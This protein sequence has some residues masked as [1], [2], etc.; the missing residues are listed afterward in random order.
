MQ[1]AEGTPGTGA[2]A[3]GARRARRRSR[4][5]GLAV[6]AGVALLLACLPAVAQEEQSNETSSEFVEPIVTEETLPNEVGEWD[7]RLSCG[8]TH[9]EGARRADCVR[10]QVFFGI[11]RGLG[12]EVS[13]PLTHAL[14]TPG[15]HGLGDFSA[16]V[17]YA[18]R[19]PTRR[20]PA[21]VLGLESTF[22]TGETS[23]GTGE[24]VYELRPNVA[25]LQKI[26]WA[27]L[28]GNV[29]YAVAVG[30]SGGE[31]GNQ[32]TFNGSAAF[33]LRS[34]QW[35]LLAEATG[36]FASNFR[37]VLVAPGIKYT[38]GRN[39]FLALG[40]PVGVTAD[41]PAF[42]VIVQMQLS[43]RERREDDQGTST[44]D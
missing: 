12:G 23:N 21:I 40:V 3:P 13:L 20:A 43:L 44:I 22:P 37:Q 35:Y 14:D 34:R 39:R 4:R 38:F 19:A 18:L 1:T 2:T 36:T 25:F 5:L 9:R 6:A 41:S 8:Y 31:E 32:G 7:L 17:K 30:K 24:G 28:Q 27:T 29:G 16:A 11:A 33:P 10:A 26:G 42:G 15:G